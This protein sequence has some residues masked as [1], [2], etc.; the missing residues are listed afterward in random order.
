MR[1]F[2]SD[3]TLALALA[4]SGALLG[5][6]SRGV[7][8]DSVLTAEQMESLN[9]QL[10]AADSTQGDLWEDYRRYREDSD[11]RTSGDRVKIGDEVIVHENE[12]ISGDVVSVGG[13]VTVY[14]FVEGDVVSIGG[15]VILQD[16]AEVMGDVVSVGGRVREPGNARVHGEKVSIN[17]PLPMNL[18]WKFDGPDFKFGP[19]R[20]LSFGLD[21]GFVAVGLLLTLLAY[22][23]AGNRL[24]VT[25][26]RAEAEPG[27]SFLVGMLGAFGTPLAVILACILLAITIIG[28]L[29]IPVLLI[30]VW[31]L[32]FGGYVAVS[33]A[34]GRRLLQS[35]AEDLPA[36]RSPYA[37]VLVGFLALQGF[38][39]LGSLFELGGGFLGTLSML[40]GILNIFILLFASTLGY[41]A[42][43]LSRFGTQLP[44]GLAV[45]STGGMGTFPYSTPPPPPPPPPAAPAGSGGQGVD[46]DERGAN[47]GTEEDTP[48]RPS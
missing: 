47:E 4:L 48:P 42:L 30:L 3:Y 13:P 33:L 5:A 12:R 25:S 32:S 17:I 18:H 8:Q 23:V 41:G 26:R 6:P 15:N 1:T 46:R 34:V 19:P 39:L 40:C 2:S 24:D 37:L 21:L 29:L 9:E 20:F 45:A 35:R 36:A 43:L 38:G 10:Q 16:G 44:P 22:A 28:L 11:V 7:A 14:G 27:Q 31:V